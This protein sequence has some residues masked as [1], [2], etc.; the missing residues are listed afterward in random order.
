MRT[1]R[2]PELGRALGGERADLLAALGRSLG[3]F[4]RPS[5]RDYYPVGQITH[6]RAEASVW[7]FR[8]LVRGAQADETLAQRIRSEFDFYSSRGSDGKGTVLFTGYYSPTFKAA[9]QRSELYRHPLYRR[10]DD[11]VVDPQTGETRGQRVGE[12]ILPYPTR[13]DIEK[14]GMLA[15]TELVWLADRFEAYLIHIQ[16]SA[17][18]ELPDGSILRVGYA[19][20][21]G[22]P[23][24]SV[25]RELVADGL[26]TEDELSADEVR[27]YFRAHPEKLGPYLQRN[28]RFVFFREVVASEWPAGS[29]GFP[30]TPLRTL[31]TDKTVFPPGGVT[32]VVTRAPNGAGGFRSFE[33]FM[34]DQDSG[35]AIRTPGRADIYF[36]VGADAAQRASGQHTEGRLFYL[37]LRPGRVA[38]WRARMQEGG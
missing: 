32:L 10:P 20:V 24:V 12:R 29:L 27:A 36:G 6:E 25:A 4:E 35:G 26:L 2:A 19:G 28:P 8:A 16:G 15:G 17:A 33:A 34:L 13:A 14:S 30:V 38:Y 31:A 7:A 5:S 18:L 22:R 1:G 11:L 9:R 37:F 3:W 23:Y 21:N